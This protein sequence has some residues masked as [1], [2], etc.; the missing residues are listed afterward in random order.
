VAALKLLAEKAGVALSVS[1]ENLTTL[2]QRKVTVIAKGCSLKSIMVQI[3]DA[4]QECHWRIDTSGPPPVYEL[5]R[6]AGVE[7]TMKWLGRHG[8]G[9]AQ[10]LWE[11]R[12][13]R[14]EEA[15]KALSMTPE[16]LAEL[17]KTDLLMARSARDP[18]ARD[19]LVIIFSLPPD[20]QRQFED[21][22]HLTWDYP[23][24]PAQLQR[25]IQR[26]GEWYV[27]E[28]AANPDKRWVVDWRDHL[29]EGSVNLIDMGTDH[30]LGVW[31]QFNWENGLL[32]DVALQPRYPSLDEGAICFTRLLVATGTPDGKTAF[33]VVEDLDHAGFRFDDAK[34]QERRKREWLEPTDPDLLKTVMLGDK[35]FADSAEVQKF[36]ADQTGL[37]VV[38]DY[39]TPSFSFIPDEARASLPL[40][41]VLYL[42]G[43][44]PFWGDV[45]LWRKLGSVLVFRRAD[46]YAMVL[47]EV[48][49]SLIS[50][51]REK[52][53][54]QKELTL[55]DLAEI[56]VALDGRGITE[57]AWPEDLMSAWVNLAHGW[58]LPFYA[59]FSLE[60]KAK[61]RSTAGLSYADMT[62]AQRRQVL[63]RATSGRPVVP[64]ND[65]AKAIFILAERSQE[66]GANPIIFT[67]LELRFPGR[68]DA[69]LVGF[70]MP[71]AP[72]PGD[73]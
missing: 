24:A 64:E 23:L 39:F 57:P 59:S 6:N 67:Q 20:Q 22:G 71:S 54:S 68:T 33:G 53:H 19:M 51:C 12:L 27:K 14:M 46:W 38:S 55:D 11:S 73:K 25:A 9:S 48:P 63:D 26:I 35:Q 45:Y 13:A 18:H 42:L 43:E 62:I 41:R 31:L 72:K 36:I 15:R 32:R 66:R 21:T 50:A 4:L 47:R 17:E 2:G 60:Q 49:E 10:R 28:T 61:L 30:G 52:L 69:A 56:A 16:Q 44:D 65:A 70:R 1:P 29:S 40:W 34:R 3:P 5:H 7:E 37:S 58:A 8:P